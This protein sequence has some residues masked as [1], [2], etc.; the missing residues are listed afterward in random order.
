VLT[1]PGTAWIGGELD[2]TLDWRIS[3]DLNLNIRYG[4]FW[5]NKDAFFPGENKVRQFFYVGMTYAF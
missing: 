5:P 4:I 1:R 3:S 2:Q